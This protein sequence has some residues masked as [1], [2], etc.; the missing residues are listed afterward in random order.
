MRKDSNN[1]L[2][3]KGELQHAPNR[4]KGGGIDLRKVNCDASHLLGLAQDLRFVLKEWNKDILARTVLV[5]ADYREIVAKSNRVARLLKPA[6]CTHPSNLVCGARFEK[7]ADT[8]DYYHVIVYKTTHEAISQSVKDLECAAQFLQKHCSGHFTYERIKTIRSSDLREVGLSQTK[9]QQLIKDAYFVQRFRIGNAPVD[10]QGDVLVSLYRV[11]SQLELIGLLQKVGIRASTSQFLNEDTLILSPDER[12]LLGEKAGWLIAMEVSDLMKYETLADASSGA[13]SPPLLPEPSNEPVVGVIDTRFDQ[14]VY[15]SNWVEYHDCINK[16]IPK[17]PEDFNHGTAVSS[18]IVNGPLMNPDLDDGCGFFRVRHFAVAAHGNMS[19]FEVLRSVRRI[20]RENPDIKVWNLSLGSVKACPENFISPEGAELDNIQRDHD[21]LCVVAGTNDPNPPYGKLSELRVGAPADALN[22]V[23]VNSC[24]KDGE[25]ASYSRRGPVL[26][27]FVKPD[28]SCF[29]GVSGDG[30]LVCMPT[31]E[32]AKCGTSFAAPWVSRKLAYMIN[33]LQMSRSE[34]KALLIDSCVG[35]KSLDEKWP[36]KGWG[37]VPCRIDDIVHGTKEEIRFIISGS[38]ENYETFSYNIPVPMTAAGMIDYDAR[39]T[40]CYF[41]ECRR[42]QGVDYTLTEL[43]LHF[44]RVDDRKKNTTIK[45][46]DQN[47]QCEEG[48]LFIP[49]ASA[50]AYFRKWDNVKVRLKTFKRDYEPFC[51]QGLWGIKIYSKE[52]L[53]ERFGQ[54]M[55]FSL[56]V[57]L[58]S[59]RG[60]DRQAEFIKACQ[61]KGWVVNSVNVEN[62]L[63]VSAKLSQSVEFD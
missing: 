59:R 61:A 33:K 29:G 15:F 34:A 43:D 40:L 54:K 28:V 36:W 13:F 22:S 12:R 45:S 57:T 10:Q 17:S 51:D 41:P 2:I 47:K 55:P 58:R 32:N 11:G 27:F 49:E 44:G 48:K 31:G 4:S 56:V 7:D 46:I 42:D 63:N 62:L 18:L 21:V 9:F 19:S 53:Q 3:L 1:I 24:T 38:I 26:H 37:C 60:E 6:A 23:V 50:R 35:W 16:D 30:M 25:P 8:G 14:S 20:V 52:R 5:T 39:A